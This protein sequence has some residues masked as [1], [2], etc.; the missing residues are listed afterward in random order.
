MTK[1][2]EPSKEIC[3]LFLPQKWL[4][5]LTHTFCNIA[6]RRRR[7]LL[8]H[9]LL[10][11]LINALFHVDH[12]SRLTRMSE[13]WMYQVCHCDEMI[14]IKNKK[15]S[16]IGQQNGTLNLLLILISSPN[17]NMMMIKKW[18]KWTHW[19]WKAEQFSAWAESAIE[20]NEN[21][22]GDFYS[23]EIESETM[24][25]KKTRVGKLIVKNMRVRKFWMREINTQ[26]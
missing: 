22:N 8:L 1:L 3:Y 24:R 11:L 26:H 13:T 15:L 25:V 20:N 7:L 9:V 14:K 6:P 21:E 17:E 12:W 19:K 5:Q 16:Q 4:F 2:K 18:W 10:L 23:E